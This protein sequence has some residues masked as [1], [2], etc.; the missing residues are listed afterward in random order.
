MKTDS[1]DAVSHA[2]SSAPATALPLHCYCCIR[3]CWKRSSAAQPRPHTPACCCSIRW[4]CDVLGVDDAGEQSRGV[5]GAA[6]W[7]WADDAT[8]RQRQRR[9]C[10]CNRG[11]SPPVD[12]HEMVAS[13]ADAARRWRATSRCCEVH[14]VGASGTDAATVL[15]RRRTTMMVQPRDLTA[16]RRTR[17]LAAKGWSQHP[18]MLRGAVT[19]AWRGDAAE[20]AGAGTDVVVGDAATGRERSKITRCVRRVFCWWGVSVSLR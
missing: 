10:C 9:R 19:E 12:G 4:C 20:V 15:R 18:L 7:W 17:Q 3:G 16:G 14:G 6:R 11:T 2:T 5:A 13:S 1:G 8:V